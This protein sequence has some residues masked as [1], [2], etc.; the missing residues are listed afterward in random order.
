MALLYARN[1]PT[2]TAPLSYGLL[3][4]VL[5]KDTVKHIKKLEVRVNTHLIEICDIWSS[6]RTLPS[7]TELVLD[8][9]CCS[10][11][12]KPVGN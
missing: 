9:N 10:E 1:I 7:I 2:I 5:S 6:L 11:L 8:M 12:L 3:H 4:H